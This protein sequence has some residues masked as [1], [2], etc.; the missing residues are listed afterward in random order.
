MGRCLVAAGIDADPDQLDN[1]PP[2]TLAVYPDGARTDELRAALERLAWHWRALPVAL[3]GLGIFPGPSSV[4][5]AAPVV[6][7]EMLARHAAL[8]AAVSGFQVH[9]HYQPG[10]WVPHVTL[11]GALPDPGRALTVLVPHWRPITGVLNQLDLV[12]FP[13]V[14]VLQSHAMLA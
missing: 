1:P 3:S 11:A 10:A 7:P 5:W 13:P 6:T 4:L 12:R 14:E 9:A 8:H 2:L